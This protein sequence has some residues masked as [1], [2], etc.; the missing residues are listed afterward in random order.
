[1]KYLDNKRKR[2]TA[3]GCQNGYLIVCLV[4]VL[5]NGIYTLLLV[6]GEMNGSYER[7]PS[8]TNS[9]FLGFYK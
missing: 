8:N 5:K 3:I 1:M 4:D 9:L 2:V 6:M 7:M